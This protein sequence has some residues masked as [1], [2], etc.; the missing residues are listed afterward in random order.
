MFNKENNTSKKNIFNQIPNVKRYDN[1]NTTKEETVFFLAEEPEETS[2]VTNVDEFIEN[3]MPKKQKRKWHWFTKA[4]IIVDICA[5]ICF[6]TVYGPIDT[7]RNWFV[8]TSVS[9][10]DHRFYAATFYS[11]DYIAEICSSYVTVQTEKNTN[12]NAIKFEKA[13]DTGVYSNIYEEQILKREEGALYKIIEIKEGN[14]SGFVTAIYDSKRVN[15]AETTSVYG[16]FIS[17]YAK[18]NDYIIA[19]NAGPRKYQDGKIYPYN[20]IISEG[21]IIFGVETQA[22][23][24]G[25]NYDGVLCL[26]TGTTQECLEKYNLKWG[27]TFGPF[28]IVNGVKT[29][30][31]GD[32]GYGRHPRTAIGQ[33]EDGIILL[34]TI[35]GRGHNGSSG[36][37]MTD[38]CDLM[39]RY[40]CYTAANLDGGGSTV[41]VENGEIVNHP[42]T[43]HMDGERRLLNCIYVK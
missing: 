29:K 41:L 28:L 14:Y 24:I 37:T 42:G 17:D 39:A 25:M 9:T 20:T 8:T 23:I 27:I 32:G 34:F 35:D 16:M 6:M 18:D 43:R 15:L 40:G 38:L 4:C 5:L 31:T 11:Q 10:A 2:I 3:L 1:K 13:T 12:T 19:V 26:V 33:R 30:F 21:K 22:K 7:F 36:I